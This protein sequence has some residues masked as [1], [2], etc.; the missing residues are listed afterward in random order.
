MKD[1]L[2]TNGSHERYAGSAGA[3][4]DSDDLRGDVA[5]LALCSL[6]AMEAD[7][8]IEHLASGCRLCARE[9][10][11]Y[12]KV[13]ERLQALVPRRP[14]SLEREFWIKELA[15]RIRTPQL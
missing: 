5:L 11:S 15:R 4:G 2:P 12:Q 6:D 7:L 1:D 9:L 8:V 14:P 10:L 3:V 13:V